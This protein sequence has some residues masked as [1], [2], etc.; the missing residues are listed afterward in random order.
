MKFILPLLAAVMLFLWPTA[1]RKRRRGAVKRTGATSR[2]QSRSSS[3]SGQIKRNS[4][5]Q[6]VDGRGRPYNVKNAPNWVRK[7]W[8]RKAVAARKKG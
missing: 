7:L 2:P 8:Q 6:I 5:G 3:N 4:R 1:A